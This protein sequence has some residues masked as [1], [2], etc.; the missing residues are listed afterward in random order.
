M[1]LLIPVLLDPGVTQL[2]YEWANGEALYSFIEGKFFLNNNGTVESDSISVQ[3][4]PG[5]IEI[6]LLGDDF[7]FFLVNDDFT[8]GMFLS[9]KDKGVRQLPGGSSGGCATFPVAAFALFFLPA[10]ALVVKR[11]QK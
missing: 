8:E 4:A 9:V 11:G 6:D 7:E 10:L 1:P 2:P 3:A 5:T